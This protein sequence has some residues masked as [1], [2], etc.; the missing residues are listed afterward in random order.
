MD[1]QVNRPIFTWPA[2]PPRP[3]PR[4]GQIRDLTRCQHPQPGTPVP[5]Q[6]ASCTA[7]RDFLRHPHS[8]NPGPSLPS[9]R[10][11]TSP[12]GPAKEQICR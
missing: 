8:E 11:E 5:Q 10:G 4:P 12:P 9:A 1:R 7:G 2:G 3:G 6:A